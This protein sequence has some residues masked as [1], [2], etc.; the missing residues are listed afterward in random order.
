MVGDTIISKS[1]Q[2]GCKVVADRRGTVHMS[3]ICAV[4]A[5]LSRKNDLAAFA[6]HIETH[7]AATAALKAV[8]AA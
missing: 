5:L 2:C 6:Q 7:I 3:S 8:A 4:G 1:P